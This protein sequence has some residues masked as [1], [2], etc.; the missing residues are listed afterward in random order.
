[1]YLELPQKDIKEARVRLVLQK[2]IE[3][4]FKERFVSNLD[5]YLKK[6]LK[7]QELLLCFEN[8]KFFVDFT[9]M[10]AYWKCLSKNLTKM[11]LSAHN[12]KVPI[13]DKEKSK[14]RYNFSK[15]LIEHD[16]WPIY[17]RMLTDHISSDSFKMGD[18]E[19]ILDIQRLSF[20]LPA[21]MNDLFFYVIQIDILDPLF[22]QL[23]NFIKNNQNN[24][25]YA[26]S[27]KALDF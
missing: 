19:S 16:F 7:D 21:L 12:Y 20:Q 3:Q 18:S 15:C 6:E 1:M 25:S 24:L 8:G 11:I 4:G 10:N 9:C 22:S 5:K 13:Y 27:F 14:S 17:T 2:D 26:D 23:Q